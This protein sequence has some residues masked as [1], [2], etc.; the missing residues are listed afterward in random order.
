MNKVGKRV[1]NIV[2]DVVIV[3]IVIFAILVSI[4]SFTAKSNNN[5]PRLF[6]YSTF[7]VQTDSMEPE[8]GVGEYIFVEDCN[9]K[10]LKKHDIITFKTYDTAGKV[11]INTHRIVDV[12]DNNDGSFSYQTKG[13]NVAEPDTLYVEEGDIIGKYVTGIPLLGSIMDFLGSKWGFFLVIL[14]PI[15]LYTIYQV[16]KLIVVVMHNKK[17]E[18]ATEV[19]ASASDDVKEAIIA[20]YLA[21]QNAA[22]TENTSINESGAENVDDAET[23]EELTENVNETQS[24]QP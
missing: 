2:V 23:S 15:L 4:T 10:N 18:M 17:V 12:I 21:Q 9:T 22:E 7:S 16:Y 20:E 13:D 3:I 11:F 8:I 1:I 6:G 14:L 19:A 24:E 5:I